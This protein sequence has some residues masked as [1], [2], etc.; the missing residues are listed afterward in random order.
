M[1]NKGKLISILSLSFVVVLYAIPHSNASPRPQA[2]CVSGA[3]TAGCDT[4]T[5]PAS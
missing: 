1:K 3:A 2:D 5:A 4:A